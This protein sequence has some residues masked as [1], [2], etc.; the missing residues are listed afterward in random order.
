MRNPVLL[1][2]VA[3]ALPAAAQAK[4]GDSVLVL[5]PGARALVAP[6][7]P[8]DAAIPNTGPLAPPH[9]PYVLLYP[10]M[11]DGV[12]MRP[13]RWY[14]HSRVIC[15]GWRSGIEAGCRTAPQLRTWLGSGSATGVFRVEPAR[16][17]EL[18]RNGVSLL[19]YGNEATAIKLALG[20]RARAAARPADC[21]TFRLRWSGPPGRVTSLCISPQGGVYAAGLVYPLPATAARFAIG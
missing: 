10:L 11:R 18:V 21:V 5:G 1:V 6:W 13:G 17:L 15:S 3:L 14:P 4:G 16:I 19:P 2:I 12:P 8:V 9:E 20:Q 7:A